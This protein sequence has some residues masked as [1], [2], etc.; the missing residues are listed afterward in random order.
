MRPVTRD[1]ILIRQATLQDLTQVKEFTHDTFS[2]GDYLPKAWE[3]LVISKRG[4]LLVADWDGQV[5]GTIR[6]GFLGNEEAWLEAVRVRHEFRE[7][8]IASVMIQA[9]HE[10]ATKRK[11]RLIRLETGAHNVAAQRA[12]EKFGY[13][14]ISRFAGYEGAA[15]EGELREVRRAKLKDTRAC[16]DLWEHSWMK[17]ASKS[18]V[19]A[20]Y[21]WRWWELTRKRLAE[22]IRGKRVWVAP[23]GFMILRDMDDGLD[24]TLLVGAKRDALK[25]LDAARVLARAQNKENVYWIAPEVAHTGAWAS[26][27]GYTL[28]EK[29]LLIY[30]REL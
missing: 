5:L 28:D 8:G 3:R 30:A 6:V 4:D 9:A 14:R 15:R 19:P 26:Q 1:S 16:W 13:R 10:R 17:R 11:C 20:V 24:V 27:A 2:W 29:G 12:F 23:R 21:G 25:L 18:V 22:D 7:R